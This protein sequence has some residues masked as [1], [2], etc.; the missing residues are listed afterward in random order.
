MYKANDRVRIVSS[1]NDDWPRNSKGFAGGIMTIDYK[2]S[3]NAYIMK[4]D[5]GFYKWTEDMF[6]HRVGDAND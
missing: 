2:T 6:S 5:N 4:D 1:S 3:G